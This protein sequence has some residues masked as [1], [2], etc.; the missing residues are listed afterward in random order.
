MNAPEPTR[1]DLKALFADLQNNMEA[2][3]RTIRKH[4]SV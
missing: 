1:V 3:L 4:V 2:R